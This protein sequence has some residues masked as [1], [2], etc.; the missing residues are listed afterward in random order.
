MHLDKGKKIIII[1]IFQ[2]CKTRSIFFSLLTSISSPLFFFTLDSC[3]RANCFADIKLSGL[4][5]PRLHFLFLKYRYYICYFLIRWHHPQHWRCIKILSLT[6]PSSC[7]RIS[8]AL[9]CKLSSPNFSLLNSVEFCCY[10]SC[11]YF[12]VH[13]ILLFEI[14]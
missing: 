11:V 6:P 3:P 9:G 14:S 5:L 7:G 1:C 8:R 10:M 2:K 4:S 13:Y 12:H